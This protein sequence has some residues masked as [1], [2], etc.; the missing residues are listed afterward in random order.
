MKAINKASKGKKGRRE[1]EQI[2]DSPLFYAMEIKKIL[3]NKTYKPSKSNEFKIIDGVSRK[4]RKI[5]KPKF[6]PDQII[7]WSIMNILE[8]YFMKWMYH[9]SCASIKE[10]EI[11][12]G[13]KYLKKIL[14]FDRK[15]TKY[16]LKLDI[17]KI[18]QVLIKKY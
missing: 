18:I 17:K 1:V 16:C 8:P 5:H 7:R 14:N 3:L 4:T 9:Y 2:L 12:Y 11:Y 13:S 15:N 10:R 6:Y